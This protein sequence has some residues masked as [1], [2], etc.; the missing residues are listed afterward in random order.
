MAEFKG[1]APEREFEVGKDEAW[2]AKIDRTY[3]EYLDIGLKYAR[4]SQGISIQILQNAIAFSNRLLHNSVTADH[5][6]TLQ[7]L[8]HRDIAVDCTWDPGPG[9]ESLKTKK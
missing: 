5:I 4:D 3:E 9:E 6:A 7:A 1:K 2:F 8:G